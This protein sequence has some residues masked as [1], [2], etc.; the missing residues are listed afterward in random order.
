MDADGTR[1]RAEMEPLFVWSA[2]YSSASFG[3][4]TTVYIVLNSRGSN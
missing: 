4:C 3:R 2:R 1:G